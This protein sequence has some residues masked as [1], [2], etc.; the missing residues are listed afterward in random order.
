VARRLYGLAA[1]PRRRRPCYDRQ[2]GRQA[3]AGT[4]SSPRLALSRRTPRCSPFRPATPPT[5]AT[6]RSDTTPRR[7][8][9]RRQPPARAVLGRNRTITTRTEF[10][11][12]TMWRSSRDALPALTC[13]LDPASRCRRRQA[14]GSFPKKFEGTG[15]MPGGPGT[16]D[17]RYRSCRDFDQI[18]TRPG[19]LAGEDGNEP[20]PGRDWHL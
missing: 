8:T 12:H 20:M 9:T 13:A 5:A 3:S 17:Q 19:F 18:A 7:P 1:Q 11:A 4:R 15:R 16:Y 2:D 10:P 6:P 14:R